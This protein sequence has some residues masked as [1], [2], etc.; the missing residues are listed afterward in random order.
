MAPNFLLDRVLRPDEEEKAVSEVVE[1]FL[2][3][4]AYPIVDN[5][6]VVHQAVQEGV[7]LAHFAIRVGDRVICR[8][9][10]PLSDLADAVLV[11]QVPDVQP[12]APAEAPAVTG[13]TLAT[14][15][16]ASIW[17]SAWACCRS[18]RS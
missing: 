6:D 2:R 13:T 3:Y 15:P 12:P 5:R 16:A 11:R 8:E 7:R 9:E 10:V 4:T 1:V 17:T 18:K 14:S